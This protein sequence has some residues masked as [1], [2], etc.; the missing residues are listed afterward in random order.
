MPRLNI[1]ID[2][3]L[4]TALKMKSLEAGT[5]LKDHVVKVLRESLTKGAT[6]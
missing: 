2:P 3:K 1:E 6:K 4:R 5:T